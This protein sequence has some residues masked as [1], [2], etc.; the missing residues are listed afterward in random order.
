MPKGTNSV[1]LVDYRSDIG[2]AGTGQATGA[3]YQSVKP[4]E[5]WD[6]FHMG[7]TRIT[8]DL[9]QRVRASPSQSPSQ[10]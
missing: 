6:A 10:A 2:T 8:A 9:R 5:M 7:I 4:S 1:G 3:G